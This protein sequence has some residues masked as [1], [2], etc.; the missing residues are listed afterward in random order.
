M[1][2]YTKRVQEQEQKR[3]GRFQQAQQAQ[4]VA[5]NG[6]P[7]NRPNTQSPQALAAQ[8]NVK[9]M[10]GTPQQAQPSGMYDDL[11]ESPLKSVFTGYAQK[12]KGLSKYM[13][14]MATS[15]ETLKR[16]TAGKGYPEDYIQAQV[17]NIVGEYKK[18]NQ[19]EVAHNQ[20]IQSAMAGQSQGQGLSAE[21]EI[22]DVAI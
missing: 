1:S 9:T 8:Q 20:R 17:K 14:E 16:K 2:T 6:L 12:D 11:P 22:L 13:E 10:A 3:L 4:G 18:R 5:T 19:E 15:F 7:L 21:Q